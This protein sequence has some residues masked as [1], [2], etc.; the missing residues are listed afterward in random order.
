MIL[1]EYGI[2]SERCQ[3]TMITIKDISIHEVA[4]PLR[5]TFATAKGRMSVMR[6][7]IVRITLA[8]GS[9]GFG[10]C[11]MSISLSKE[12]IPVIKGVLNELRQQLHGM[13]ILDYETAIRLF[14]K[15]YTEYPMTT[16]GLEVALFRAN[17]ACKGITE[18]AYWGGKT[19]KVQTDITIPFVLDKTFLLR[20]MNYA[21]RKGFTTYKL[22]VS[23]NVEQ[24]K[25]ILSFVHNRLSSALQG[26]TLCLDGNQGYNKKTFRHIVSYIQRHGFNIEFFEQPLSKDDY[27][28]FKEIKEFAPFPIILDESVIT[29]LDAK[30]LIEKNLAHG[31]N[32]KIAKSGVME[33]TAI[34]D[35]A[36]KHGLKLMIGCMTETMIGL[37]SAINL[38]AGTDAFDYI[39]LD[40][41]FF[42]YH[43]NRF[44]NVSLQGDCFVIQP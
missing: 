28:G 17:L 40:S 14:R 34:M 31:I 1:F 39:D 7:I 26:F 32:I 2:C 24:D 10:E 44:R 33:S 12:T 23:G 37:S 9:S 25:V 36:R 5:I 20:W 6:S 35:I 8:D 27:H 18:R 13:S 29:E 11:P 30:R 15:K 4:R 43:K 41:V 42:L 16:S 38:A 3:L 22:K 21:L 19:K